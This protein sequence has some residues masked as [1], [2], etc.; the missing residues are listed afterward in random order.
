[1]PLYKMT[2]WSIKVENSIKLWF[3]SLSF[4]IIV[5]LLN[6]KPFPAVVKQDTFKSTG[7][8][9]HMYSQEKKRTCRIPNPKL[10][11]QKDTLNS[12]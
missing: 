12:S 2:F 7:H 3:A 5:K 9:W 11:A 6:L 1:M 8:I 10:V 4:D